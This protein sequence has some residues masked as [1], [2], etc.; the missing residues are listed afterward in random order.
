VNVCP[1]LAKRTQCAVYSTFRHVADPEQ[2]IS[3]YR[4]HRHF[5]RM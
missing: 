4:D 3:A 1:P 5:A 2:M